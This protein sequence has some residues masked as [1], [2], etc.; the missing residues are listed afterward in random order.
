ML[1]NV[2]VSIEVIVEPLIASRMTNA[3]SLGEEKSKLT[4]EFPNFNF[5]HLVEKR[6]PWFA[7]FADQ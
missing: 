6:V 2:D 4:S 7:S 3:W 1:R 5:D